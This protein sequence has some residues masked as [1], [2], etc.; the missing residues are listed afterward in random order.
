MCLIRIQ[1]QQTYQSRDG[2]GPALSD[3]R[4]RVPH[5]SLH[6]PTYDERKTG[7]EKEDDEFCAHLIQGDPEK[8]DR[9]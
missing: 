8:Y 7:C 5:M 6:H 1:K 4:E 3:F 2:T 9:N